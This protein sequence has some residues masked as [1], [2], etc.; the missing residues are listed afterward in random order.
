M[1]VKRACNQ[2]LWSCIPNRGPHV[3]GHAWFVVSAINTVRAHMH[4]AQFLLFKGD[5]CIASLVMA[6]IESIPSAEAWLHKFLSSTPSATVPIE[7]S[8]KSLTDSCMCAKK[9]RRCN[10][11]RGIR[12]KSSTFL[13]LSTTIVSHDAEFSEREVECE[14]IHISVLSKRLQEKLQAIAMK[15]MSS[16]FATLSDYATASSHIDSIWNVATSPYGRTWD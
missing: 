9:L 16:W 7:L 12:Y 8:M 1:R 2:D 5:H 13:I 3:N 11:G 10:C 15:T 6:T 4:V 14:C